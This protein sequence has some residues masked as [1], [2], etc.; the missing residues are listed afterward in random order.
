MQ[1]PPGV[2]NVLAVISCYSSLNGFPFG[3][4]RE[5]S[6]DESCVRVCMYILEYGERIKKGYLNSGVRNHR[7]LRQNMPDK[8][9]LF[10]DFSH[11]LT[12]PRNPKDFIS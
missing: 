12:D 3:I 4:E 6:I 5:L 10:H 2:G 7:I 8:Y 11:T 9:F 1:I